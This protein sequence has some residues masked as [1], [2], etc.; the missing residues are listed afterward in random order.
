M[1][2]C[3]PQITDTG[4]S[5]LLSMLSIRDTAPGSLSLGEAHST[6]LQEFHPPP[7]TAGPPPPQPY[8]RA[9]HPS[10]SP[11]TST[12]EATQPTTNPKT[13]PQTLNL[14]SSPRAA[15]KHTSKP[16]PPRQFIE[17]EDPPRPPP[18]QSIN[19]HPWPFLS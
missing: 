8:T 10:Y 12:P 16:P 5:D 19:Q 13:H 15:S 6:A 4:F 7:K 9:H 17:A 14:M 11:N 1:P 18:N 2:H 3:L